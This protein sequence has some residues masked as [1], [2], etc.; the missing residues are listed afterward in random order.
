MEK[1]YLNFEKLTTDDSKKLFGGFSEAYSAEMASDDD[2]VNNC[3][4][5]NC[6]SGCNNKGKKSKKGTKPKP[7]PNG[8]CGAGKNCIKG[9]GDK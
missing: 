9:C 4:G 2:G 8:N 7:I 5:G 1:N 6:K 3:K